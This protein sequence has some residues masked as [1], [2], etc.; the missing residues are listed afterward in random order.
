MAE[1][2]SFALVQLCG[3]ATAFQAGTLLDSV[4]PPKMGDGWAFH[5]SGADPHAAL[6]DFLDAQRSGVDSKC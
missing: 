1:G 2:T 4:N 5:P 3:L 6:F